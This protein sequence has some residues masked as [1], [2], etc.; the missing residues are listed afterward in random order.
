MH[1]LRNDSA[2]PQTFVV[3]D[4]IS[5]LGASRIVLLIVLMENTLENLRKC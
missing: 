5:V 2:D 3:V 1:E 4:G